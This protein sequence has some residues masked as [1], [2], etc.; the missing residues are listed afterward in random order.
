[1]RLIDMHCDTIWM[2]IREQ[3]KNLQNNPFCVDVE[4]LKRAGAMAQFF[5]CFIYMDEITG[6]DSALS[7]LNL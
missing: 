3:N 5:A 4:K 6:E 2:L 7:A 1:M